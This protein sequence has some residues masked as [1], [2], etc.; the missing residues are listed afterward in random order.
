M[1]DVPIFSFAHTQIER[2]IILPM[3]KYSTE[4]LL[5]TQPSIEPVS[6]SASQPAVSQSG[7]LTGSRH[8]NHG[9]FALLAADSIQLNRCCVS[10]ALDG[11]CCGFCGGYFRRLPSPHTLDSAVATNAQTNAQADLW[12]TSALAEALR[13]TQEQQTRGRTHRRTGRTSA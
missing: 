12:C 7:W 4:I 5:S 9:G 3:E 8:N 2:E 1:L 11:C 6:Q 13:A 10:G